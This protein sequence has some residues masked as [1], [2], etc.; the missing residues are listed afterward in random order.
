M[1]THQQPTSI[2]S[3]LI[4]SS[5]QHDSEEL[6]Q[7][8]ASNDIAATPNGQ[9]PRLTFLEEVRAA[10][11]LR[12]VQR[13]EQARV[14]AMKPDTVAELLKR[15]MALGYQQNES[16]DDEQGDNEGHDSEWDD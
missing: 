13:E 12:K 15:R 3:S 9:P 5:F 6:N 14:A 4:N 8:G 16:S 11:Q 2:E 7:L 1:P 10:P